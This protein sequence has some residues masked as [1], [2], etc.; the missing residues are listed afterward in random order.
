MKKDKRLIYIIL[1]IAIF[2]VSIGITYAY[3]SVTTSVVGDRNDIRASTGTL[4]ILYVDGPEIVADD[5]LPGWTETKVITV[6]NTGT[7]STNYTITWKSIQNEITNDELTYNVDC[8][9]SIDTCLGISN[10][11]VGENDILIGVGIDPGE[12]HTYTITFS[13]VE[14]SSAQNYNQDK[15]FNGEINIIS[16]DEAYMLRGM[17]VDSG[18]NPIDGATVEVHSIVRTGTTNSNGEFEITGIVPGDHELYIK[19]TEGVTIATDNFTLVEAETENAEGSQIA[20]S[21]L[22]GAATVQLSVSESSINSIETYN[23]M[24]KCTSASNTLRCKALTDNNVKNDNVRSTYVTTSNGINFDA[25]ASLTNGQG[26]YFNKKLEDGKNAYFRGSS[27]CAYTNYGSEVYGG[28]NCTSAGGTWSTATRSCDLSSNRS[29]CTS[30]GFTYYDLKNNVTF[31]GHNWKIIRID[32]S[33]SIRMILSDAS[34]STFTYNYPSAD[35]ARVGYM[36]GTFEDYTS[37]SAASRYIGTAQSYY[38]GDSFARDQYNNYSLA[39]NKVSG[40]WNNEAIC[41]STS[42]PVAN[43]YTC[44]STSSTGNCT[45]LYKISSFSDSSY[46]NVYSVT[47]SS[48]SYDGAHQN[49]NNSIMKTKNDEWYTSNLSSYSSY[50]SDP[51]FCNDRSLHSGVGY[52]SNNTYFSGVT[53][54]FWSNVSPRLTCPNSNRDLFTTSSSSIGNKKLTYPIGLLTADEAAYSGMK[55]NN[56]GATDGNYNTTYLKFGATYYTMTPYGGTP[57][58]TMFCIYNNASLTQGCNFDTALGLRPVISLKP[59]TIVSSGLGT[60]D[61]PYVVQ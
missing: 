27:F 37:S 53:R 18:G 42:C 21:T 48:T 2:L 16:A 55:I 14:I 44:F 33:G 11:V 45:T 8:E 4:S 43:Y 20:A 49:I 19:D 35:M 47:Y 50:L 52:G 25:K 23:W 10:Q 24:T 34:V 1:V 26:I 3:F 39:G 17:V 41:N 29:T 22:S 54:N 31:A 9:S 28:T 15:K 30:K 38:Y 51:G 56:L 6:E 46:G 36:Y 13:F 60:Y 32:E 12:V 7:L 61:N 58:P 40:L 59:N 5:I 57:V